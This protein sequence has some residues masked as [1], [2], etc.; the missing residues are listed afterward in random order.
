MFRIL[1]GAAALLAV[2]S[3][4]ASLEVDALLAL[5]LEDSAFLAPSRATLGRGQFS[6]SINVRTVNEGFHG[7]YCNQD[8][9]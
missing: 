1:V 8:V 6:F 7:T 2:E 9:N 3:R 5:G 4:F